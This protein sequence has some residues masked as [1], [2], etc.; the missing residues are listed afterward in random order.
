MSEK[1]M[2]GWGGVVVGWIIE[3]LCLPIEVFRDL[4]VTFTLRFKVRVRTRV[5]GRSQ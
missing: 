1:F 5:G 2:V 3:S 4:Y